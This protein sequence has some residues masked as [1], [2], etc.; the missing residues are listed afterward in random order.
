[1]GTATIQ[2]IRILIAIAGLAGVLALSPAARAAGPGHYTGTTSDGGSWIA[3]VPADWNGT[4]LLY[5][6]GYGTLT[7]ADAPDPATQTDLLNRGY[8]LAGSS[9]D[10]HGSL[11]ALGSAVRDQF[12]TLSAV[13]RT[14][15]PHRPAHVL[16]VGT[17][18]GGLI[19]ALEDQRSHRRI[20]GALTTCGIVAGG[21]DLGNYQLDGEYAMSRLL[22]PSE[23]IQLVNYGTPAAA[24]T[25]AGQLQG[26]GEQAQT[27]PQGRARLALAMAFLNV[28][29]WAPGQAMP[30]PHDY[31][32]QE[33]E[34]YFTEF[35]G[36]PFPIV[37][38]IVEGRQQT[39]QAAG[40]NPSWDRGVDFA[41]QLARS[42]YR[43]EVRALYRQAGLNLA[44]DL[45]TLT[46][47]ARV[48]ADPAA[49]RWTERT[50]VP[51]GRLQVPELT[52][53]TIA[54]DLVPVQMETTYRRAVER[55][56][57]RSLLRQAYVQRQVHC[58]FT[59]AELVTGVQALQRRVVRG[60]WGSLANPARLQATANALHLGPAAF[61][62]YRP[63]R[64]TGDNGPFDPFT[65]SSWPDRAAR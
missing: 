20:D 37:P 10:P 61:V 12:Q 17:S 55:A 50:S 3:D 15:L 63:G 2:R 43:A 4:L 57:S 11:W 19:S 53:H 65:D 22:A 41:R 35:S 26:L 46:R 56:G 59:P 32:A 54:D 16:A 40:G 38:F 14:V 9:Y 18:M 24:V 1:M 45:R 51:N 48:T 60:R 29:T 6:H 13:K 7:A 5:S 27:T 52:M 30:A 44:V 31:A 39:E 64:L 33:Q 62:A 42:P 49:V 58:N 21:V 25:A 36:V 47:D 34:Q 28:T 8:A 23:P